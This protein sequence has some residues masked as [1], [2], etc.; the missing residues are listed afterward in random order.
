MREVLV[1]Y[2]LVPG[3]NIMLT[4]FGQAH[5]KKYKAVLGR[6]WGRYSYR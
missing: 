5:F 3:L 2:A 4:Q 6:F 1:F